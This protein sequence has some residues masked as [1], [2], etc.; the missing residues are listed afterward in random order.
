MNTRP[1]SDRTRTSHSSLESSHRDASNG[2]KIKSLASIDHE[3]EHGR[4][5]LELDRAIEGQ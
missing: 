5:I 1:S 3:I 4:A 2:G